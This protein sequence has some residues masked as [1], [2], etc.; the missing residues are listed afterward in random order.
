MEGG[1]MDSLIEK[2]KIIAEKQHAQQ[3]RKFDNT[4]MI[5][6]PNRVAGIVH[7]YWQDADPPVAEVVA[8]AL[9]H[10]VIEDT[11]GYTFL[12]MEKDFG[13][14]VTDM[15]EILTDP[16]EDTPD[17][18]LPNKSHYLHVLRRAPQAYGN[19]G[20]AAI[21]IACADK[22]DNLDYYIQV[23]RKCLDQAC[24][25]RFTKNPK[26]LFFYGEMTRIAREMLGEKE[27]VRVLEARL[28][29]ARKVLEFHEETVPKPF[30][31]LKDI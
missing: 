4:P 26:K 21:V 7:R 9:L 23:Y 22:L 18:W 5:T 1:I 14:N 16:N 3:H 28:A 31:V 6:H 15:V 29:E 11:R 12:D 24:R 30:L 27:I 8:A 25:D 20:R 19:V 13:K 17:F 10:D 2:A